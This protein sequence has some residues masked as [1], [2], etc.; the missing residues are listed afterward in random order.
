MNPYLALS[1]ALR[2]DFMAMN[3]SRSEPA[4]LGAWEADE[5]LYREARAAADA[6]GAR[7]LL[8]AL[9]AAAQVDAGHHAF[10]ARLGF[11]VDRAWLRERVPQER[12]AALCRREG[13]D[14]ADLLPAFRA[15]RGGGLFLERD[16]HYSPRGEAL[17]DAAL[18]PRLEAAL[19][20]G[21]AQTATL[22]P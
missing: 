6:L 7:L 11:R 19:S 22:S 5:K 12:L 20:A 9:P 10:F 1:A 21:R 18:G 16:D 3:L 14:C 8:V 2:P 4:A 17:A 13:L 15:A